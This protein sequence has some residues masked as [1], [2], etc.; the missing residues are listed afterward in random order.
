MSCFKLMINLLMWPYPEGKIDFPKRP[1]RPDLHKIFILQKFAQ[2][3][4]ISILTKDSIL[5]KILDLLQ[6]GTL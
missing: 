3:I 5:G 4:V 2:I 6:N 1:S